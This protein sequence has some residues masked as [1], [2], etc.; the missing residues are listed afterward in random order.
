MDTAKR[1]KKV[2]GKKHW[3]WFL[4]FFII[5]VSLMN[6]LLIFSRLV[7]EEIVAL[8]DFISTPV[9]IGP[10]EVKGIYISSWTASESD[11]LDELIDYILRT[12]LNAA[13]IDIKDA[14][15]RIAY[16][17]NIPQAE[18]WGTREL[19]IKDLKALLKKFQVRG[20]YTIARISVFRDS[21]LANKRPDIALKDKRY[22]DPWKDS[23][24]ISWMDP[25][26]T[27][28]WE[29]NVALA[30]EALEIGFEEINFDYIRFPSDGSLENISYPL[31]DLKTP[32]REIIKGFFK[33]QNKELSGFGRSSADLFGMTLWHSDTNYDMN[34][35]QA[36][37]D[38]LPYFDYISP[39]LYPSHFIGVFDD[40]DNPAD[41]P[42]EVIFRNFEK[43]NSSLPSLEQQI[44]NEYCLEDEN[45]GAECDANKNFK[46]AKI[47]PWI[48]AFNMGAEYRNPEMINLQKQAV[49]D[50]GGYGWLLWNA[51]NDYSDIEEALRK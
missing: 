46:I 7:E 32:R 14:G 24:G 5:G 27:E 38:A 35:G 31:W 11:M 40:M 50:G 42:Y 36:L 10:V 48:Q 37:V 4:L 25:A 45:F 29:Y 13:V 16:A 15:G 21:V 12:E 22:G 49:A 1:L 26:S 47:R 18:K 3:A 17:S 23:A 9:R 2:L 43:F 51:Q 44:K 39:M 20:I 6:F 33:Y 34:I 30:K 41:Y 8:N 19:R 28:V